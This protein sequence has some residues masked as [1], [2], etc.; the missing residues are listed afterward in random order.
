MTYKEAIKE[1][2][3]LKNDRGIS[4]YQRTFGSDG[5]YLGL[6]LTQLK[7]LA[8]KIKINPTLA[9]Q[10]LDS[11]YFEAKMLSFM[12]DD[13]KQYELKHLEKIIQ[14]LPAKYNESPL[15]Y[16][17]MVFTDFITSK[18]P[19]AKEIV[20]NFHKNK[21]K[22]YRFIAYS[23]LASLGKNKTIEE[24]YFNQFLPE[25]ENNIQTEENNVKDAMNNS[26]FYWGQRSKELNSKVIKSFKKNGS[27]IVDYGETSC[28]TPD[29]PKILQSDRIQKKL[30]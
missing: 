28:K 3:A 23:T 15:S 9:K 14:S 24:N 30:V 18:S 6:G 16:F 20:S 11:E 26:L 17:T 8:K 13:P 10:L 4:Y 22:V 25:I 19:H 12:V 5:K 1:L 2:E 21:N 27:V 29:V 7:K